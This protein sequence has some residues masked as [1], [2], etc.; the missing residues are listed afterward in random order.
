MCEWRRD[1]S[2]QRAGR[3][4]LRLIPLVKET[5][6]LNHELSS[7]ES[8]HP[9]AANNNFHLSALNII[10]VKPGGDQVH[11]YNTVYSIF[12]V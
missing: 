12:V 1:M 4:L 7:H 10:F 3:E 2:F 6:K 8:L 11:Y 5:D 9:T